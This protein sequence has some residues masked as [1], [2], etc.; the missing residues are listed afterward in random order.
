MIAINFIIHIGNVMLI[1]SDL[2]NTHS[3]EKINIQ[4]N[5]LHTKSHNRFILFSIEETIYC[6][7]QNKYYGSNSFKIY[8]N[9]NVL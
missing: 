8:L 5:F 4:S 2:S 1:L 3:I 6:R 9:V 7:L